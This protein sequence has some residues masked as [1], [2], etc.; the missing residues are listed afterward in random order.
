MGGIVH[1]LMAF[2]SLKVKLY[3]RE[4]FFVCFWKQIEIHQLQGQLINYL[5][6][7]CRR[8]SQSFMKKKHHRIEKW[9]GI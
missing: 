8:A 7:V 2:N 5:K 9:F 1:P 6:F 3:T 4:Y